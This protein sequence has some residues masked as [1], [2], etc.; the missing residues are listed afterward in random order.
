M[1]MIAVFIPLLRNAN[2]DEEG[3]LTQ[4]GGRL[5][6]VC[7]KAAG[8]SSESAECLDLLQCNAEPAGRLE[9]EEEEQRDEEGCRSRESSP[10]RSR[11]SSS[12]AVTDA[13]LPKQHSSSQEGEVPQHQ[14]GLSYF[15]QFPFKTQNCTDISTDSPLVYLSHPW[16]WGSLNECFNRCVKTLPWHSESVASKETAKRFPGYLRC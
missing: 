11:Q 6:S 8:I 5:E 12:D 15:A 13:L 3:T 16:I 10:E 14:K 1:V 9:V 7:R 2:Q 4:S